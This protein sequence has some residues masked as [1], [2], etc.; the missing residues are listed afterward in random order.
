MRAR[1]APC[2]LDDKSTRRLGRAGDLGDPSTR[3]LVDLPLGDSSTRRLQRRTILR[4]RTSLEPAG[5]LLVTAPTADDLAHLRSIGVPAALL[6]HVDDPDERPRIDRDED[7]LLIVVRFPYRQLDQAVPFVSLPLS[8]FLTPGAIA[9]VA[10]HSSVYLEKELAAD[11]RELRGATRTHFVLRLMRHLAGEFLLSLRDLTAAVDALES[12]LRRS[13]RN[14]ELFE[15]LR[16]QKSLVYF[17]TSLTANELLLERL[18]KATFI[19]WDQSDRDLLQDVLVET[20]QALDMVRIQ[21]NILANMMDA[22]ASIVSN[23]LNT[24]M[25]FLTAA[26][27]IVAVPTL[28]ASIYG[29]NVALP[30]ARSAYAFP[31]ILA[32]SVVLSA[33]LAVLFVKKRW[34]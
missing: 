7:V 13:Q 9:M 14:A 10:P 29:M 16:Y 20:R 26:T 32:L 28:I 5:S 15:L 12:A 22:F 25:K 27:I 11:L 24:V 3:R 33:A 4:V 31:T 23:N 19:E 18:E 2:R 1:L 8:I 6:S 30:G 34:F 17:S 21:E